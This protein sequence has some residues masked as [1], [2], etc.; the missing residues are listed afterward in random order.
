MFPLVF[1]FCVYICVCVLCLHSVCNVYFP[2]V[3]F[4][5][6][7]TVCVNSLCFHSICNVYICVY[8]LHLHCLHSTCS[9]HILSL[10]SES[11]LCAYALFVQR[12]QPRERAAT[13]Y[14][15]KAVQAQSS[16]SSKS[17]WKTAKNAVGIL[18]RVSKLVFFIGLCCKRDL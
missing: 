12:R 10:H 18:Y 3:I 15:S 4:P 17:F 2:Y 9:L 6:V 7:F 11:T 16:N 5:F 13:V 8:I 14:G 1:T